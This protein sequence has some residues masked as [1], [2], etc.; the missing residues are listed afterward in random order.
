[1]PVGSEILSVQTQFD[2][3]QLWA[4][5]NPSETRKETRVFKSYGTG[6]PIP[7]N[8]GKFIGTV[9]IHSGSLIFHVFEAVGGQND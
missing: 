9:Q 1:M 5:V 4:L 8:P 3:P 2:S 7:E 6:H